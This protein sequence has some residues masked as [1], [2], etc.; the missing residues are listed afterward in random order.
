MV[1]SVTGALLA[2]PGVPA[3]VQF[4]WADI[5]APGTVGLYRAGDPVNAVPVQMKPME[6][7]GVFVAAP[8]GVVSFILPASLITGEYEL[9]AVSLPTIVDG[10]TTYTVYATDALGV[11]PGIS[12]PLKAGAVVTLDLGSSQGAE[13]G[14]EYTAYWSGLTNPGEK[15]QIGLYLARDKSPQASILPVPLFTAGTVSGNGNITIPAT[16]PI[17]AALLILY[18]I[19]SQHPTPAF[20]TQSQPF[21]IL[22]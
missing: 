12:A 15:D 22:A 4:A 3:S 21:W 6:E 8:S 19:T 5:P 17:E 18:R 9:R 13:R 10:I 16:A 7:S 14:E 2:P 11:L 20:V 1:A